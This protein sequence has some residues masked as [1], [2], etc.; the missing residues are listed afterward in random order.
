M[1]VQFLV[2]PGSLLRHVGLSW[3]MW[4][5][6]RQS[7]G[8]IY[9]ETSMEVMSVEPLDFVVFDGYP[10]KRNMTL[11]GHF[12]SDNGKLDYA[13]AEVRKRV[14]AALFCKFRSCNVGV[15]SLEGVAQ[16]VNRHLW[17]VVKYR[18]NNW[19]FS[20]KLG[21]QMDNLQ[22][23]CVAIAACIAQKTDEDV[24][25]FHRRRAKSVGVILGKTGRWSLM[26]ARQVCAWN[27]HN[28]RNSSGLLGAPG[29]MQ[30][31]PASWLRSL[32]QQYVPLIS[33][34]VNAFTAD[35]GRLGTRTRRGPPV[36][37]WEDGVRDARTYVEN[38]RMTGL[39]K[40]PTRRRAP[41]NVTIKTVEAMTIEQLDRF[42]VI[43]EE[44]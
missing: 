18:S 35:A 27:D 24:T 2:W 4:E 44:I 14:L 38:E 28:L 20:K 37:R 30:V 9:K 43:Q 7:W 29:I 39:L 40:F 42:D 41:Q 8:L 23:Q 11:L 22:S 17:P 25:E 19:A 15:L 3:D 32:R 16:E 12:S 33:S 6:L 34:A 26:W 13:W 36:K 5:H 21:E 31:R 10:V 1:Q